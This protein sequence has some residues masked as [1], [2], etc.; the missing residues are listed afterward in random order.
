METFA[1]PKKMVGNS[2]FQK[3]RKKNING[4]SEDMIDAPILK[5]IQV[6]NSYSYCFTLQCCFGHFVYQGQENPDNF[7]SL[8][9]NSDINSFEYRIAYITFCLDNN[10]FGQEMLAK[11]KGITSIDPKNIQLCSAEWFW[12]K[13]VNTYSLQV[14]PDRFKHKDSVILNYQEALLIEKVRNKFYDQLYKDFT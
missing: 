9:V 11:L 10:T 8:P 5:L 14:E 12:K 2:H 13:Q 4:L 6:V 3:Q 7:E 1:E